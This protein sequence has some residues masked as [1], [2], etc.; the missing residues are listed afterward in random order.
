MIV[1]TNAASDH[2][3]HILSPMRRSDKSYHSLIQPGRKVGMSE[4]GHGNMSWCKRES[5]VVCE[6]CNCEKCERVLF[7]QWNPL[8]TSK[9][10]QGS[11]ECSTRQL[12]HSYS[13]FLKPSHSHF[14]TIT[15]KWLLIYHNAYR[16]QP[17]LFQRSLNHNPSEVV[18]G[19]WYMNFSVWTCGSL[20]QLSKQSDNLES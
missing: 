4:C 17:R 15:P 3:R 14:Q 9:F 2:V 19:Q 10:W 12:L 16:P 11:F 13:H 7:H 8:E 18:H 20:R 5:S 6:L 1:D